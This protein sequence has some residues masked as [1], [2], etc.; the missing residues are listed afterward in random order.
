MFRCPGSPGF[1]EEEEEEDLLLSSLVS[2]ING[3]FAR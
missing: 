2:L 3:A 1:P